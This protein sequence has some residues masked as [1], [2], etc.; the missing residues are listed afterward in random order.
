MAMSTNRIKQLRIEKGLTLGQLA[1][2]VGLSESH[3]SRVEAG[4]RGVKL[5]ELGALA[6]VLVP[7]QPNFV[8]SRTESD[9]GE[10][11][12]RGL[13]RDLAG[14]EKLESLPSARQ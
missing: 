6:K 14:T 5:S 2:K 8:I 1:E 9:S 10:N 11:Q 12:G 3:L 13:W 4:V 7:Y